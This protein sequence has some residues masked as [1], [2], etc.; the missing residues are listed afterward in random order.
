[1]AQMTDNGTM[2]RMY[3]YFDAR[4]G[5]YIFYDIR[6][7]PDF[8]APPEEGESLDDQLVR[9]AGEMCSRTDG[10]LFELVFE[11]RGFYNGKRFAYIAKNALSVWWY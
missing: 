8:I 10:E 6:I 1:M 9:V 11:S 5:E 2:C 4:T 3:P 7:D